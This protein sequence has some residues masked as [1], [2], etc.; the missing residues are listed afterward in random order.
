M[1]LGYTLDG[2]GATREQCLQSDKAQQITVSVIA[3]EDADEAFPNI[4][5]SVFITKCKAL[6]TNSIF[7]LVNLPKM[8]NIGL[9]TQTVEEA[10]QIAEK[11]CQLS[12]TDW[13]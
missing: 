2:F 12:N 9:L 8:D 11:R 7:Y 6:C 4:I 13:L 5:E 1:I 10:L 3:D